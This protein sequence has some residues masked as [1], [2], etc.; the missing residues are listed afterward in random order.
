[1]PMRGMDSL[2]RD[3]GMGGRDR[4][5]PGDLR[6]RAGFVSF[7]FGLVLYLFVQIGLVAGPILTRPVPPGTTD[8]YVYIAKAQQILGCF[9]QRCP[10]LSDL[11]VQVVIPKGAAAKTAKRRSL[12][13]QR[14]LY[15]YH[16]AHS[17]LLVGL[18]SLG[19]GWE[20]ALNTVSIAGAVIIAFGLAWLLYG[21]FG[22]GPAGLALAILAFAIYPGYH[23]LHWVVPSNIAFGIGLLALAGVVSRPRWLHWALPFAV[24]AMVWMH[25]AG[26][27]YAL[28]ALALY[29]GLVFRTEPRRWVTLA[30]SLAALASPLLV[31]ALVERPSMSFAGLEGVAG[32]GFLEGVVKNARAALWAVYPWLYERGGFAILGLAAVGLWMIEPA[33]AAG[34]RLL[35]A[36]CACLSAASLLYV[37][38]NYPAELFHRLWVLFAAV[39][40]GTAS[41]ALWTGTA[42]LFAAFSGDRPPGRGPARRYVLLARLGAGGA[43][44]LVSLYIGIGSMV[45]GSRA[46]LA[47]VQH[48]IVWG[49]M[50][51]D[52][53]QPGRV[54]AGL[55]ARARV[56]YLDELSFVFY[57]SRGGLRHGAVFGPAVEGTRLADRYYRAGGRVTLAVKALKDFYGLLPLRGERP[58]VVRSARPVDWSLARIKLRAPV[59]PVTLRV[60][61]AGPEGRVATI[62]VA[63]DSTRWHALGLPKGSYATAIAIIRGDGQTLASIEGLRLAPTDRRTWPWDRGIEILRWNVSAGLAAALRG[64]AKPAKAKQKIVFRHRFLSA[65]LVPKGCRNLG[66]IEDYGATVAS[67]VSC[68]GPKKK[69]TR[70]R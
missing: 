6:L 30:W 70:Q 10:A 9:R 61:L 63:A 8:A 40:T 37:L 23:G 4:A 60:R 49:S 12:A 69:T 11:R 38:P 3:R 39:A 25:P 59:K 45:N 44:A 36:L 41:Y 20:A 52:R 7:G 35:F 47:K 17:A 53:G 19:L 65:D 18:K 54:L 50:P 27:I 14:E 55:G 26:R 24:L 22:A 66:I 64:P 21:V 13:Y 1:M 31:G 46:A 51:L 43:I 57:A 2:A 32:W 5:G 62:T 16:L 56:A 33:R 42:R 15:Q 68:G 34:L 48:M 28:A 58:I 29:G 67:R